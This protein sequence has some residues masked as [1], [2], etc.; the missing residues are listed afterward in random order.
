MYGSTGYGVSGTTI[1]TASLERY[2]SYKEFPPK[3][4]QWYGES[5][6]LIDSSQSGGRLSQ[7]SC[8]N[9]DKADSAW[10]NID[11]AYPTLH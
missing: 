6:L 5:K 8:K 7:P 11:W 4:I 1:P 2:I 9:I 3:L 10:S